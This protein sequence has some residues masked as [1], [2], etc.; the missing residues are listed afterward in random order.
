MRISLVLFLLL[1]ARLPAAAGDY[2]I[3]YL[4]HPD[5]ASVEAYKDKVA[6]LLGPDLARRLRVVKGQ[7]NYG[8]VY[9]RKGGLESAVTVASRHSRLLARKGL[10][11]AAP[12]AAAEW[13][14]AS[15]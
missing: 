2:H 11:P 1:A 5:L 9:P 8:L 14:D 7:D 3:S 10:E 15:V 13:Q 6:G 12:V 4:W